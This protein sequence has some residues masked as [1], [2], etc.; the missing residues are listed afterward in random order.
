MGFDPGDFPRTI[1][2]VHKLVLML[3]SSQTPFATGASE[4]TNISFRYKENSTQITYTVDPSYMVTIPSSVTLGSDVTIS[5]EN[6]RVL[7]TAGW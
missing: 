5:A 2:G 3:L 4:F 7:R 6:V 1:D